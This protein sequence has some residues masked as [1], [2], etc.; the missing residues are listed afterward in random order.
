MHPDWARSIRDQCQDAG[1][2]LFFKQWGKLSNNPDKGDPT[3]KKNGG[4]AKGGSM[5]DGRTWDE[6][7]TS[8]ERDQEKSSAV[9]L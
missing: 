5:L 4:T 6:M 9:A 2:P 3:A 1:V 8:V 7:P